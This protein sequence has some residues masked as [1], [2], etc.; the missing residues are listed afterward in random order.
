MPIPSKVW[1]QKK[2]RRPLAGISSVLCAA[3]FNALSPLFG[4]MR[5]MQPA[6]KPER[7]ITKG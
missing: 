5:N 1:W 6:K 4:G 2:K 7:L 3:S